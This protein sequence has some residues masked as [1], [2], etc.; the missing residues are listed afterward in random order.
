MSRKIVVALGAALLAS[1]AFAQMPPR[2]HAF[3]DAD[4]PRFEQ[5]MTPEQKAK[6][7]AEWVKTWT[8]REQLH[9]DQAQF[10]AAM[11]NHDK[12]AVEVIRPKLEAD[13]SAL[14]A[15]R[16]LRTDIRGNNDMRAPG[17]HGPEGGPGEGFG[18]PPG[19]PGGP[20]DGSAPPSGGPAGHPP[21]VRD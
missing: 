18:P 15:E 4:G 17:A 2:D 5:K 1:T 13:M 11:K 7:E 9:R 19:G 10:D 3:P 21:L 14:H 6:F 12:K 20:S 16:H 8:L